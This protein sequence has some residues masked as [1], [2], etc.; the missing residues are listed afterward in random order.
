MNPLHIVSLFFD[1]SFYIIHLFTL[2]SSKRF[3]SF[4]LHKRGGGSF[5]SER[6]LA[7]QETFCSTGLLLH[8]THPVNPPPLKTGRVMQ[9][10]C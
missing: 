1:I 4:E 9:S 5:L 10:R 7:S 8:F 3:L 2:I 6:L